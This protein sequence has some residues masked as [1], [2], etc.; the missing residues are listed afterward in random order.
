M[1][2]ASYSRPVRTYPSDADVVIGGYVVRDPGLT[3]LAGRYLF[4]ELR[5]RRSAAR[6]RTAAPTTDLAR[7][8]GAVGFGEDGAGHLYATSLGGPVCRLAQSGSA[9]ATVEHR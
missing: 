3:G 8:P 9:L 2:G 7:R 4:A 5:Q 1:P 6:A